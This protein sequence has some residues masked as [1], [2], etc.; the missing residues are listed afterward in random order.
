M[1]QTAVS[2]ERTTTARTAPPLTVADIDQ[3]I[4]GIEEFVMNGN[5]EVDAIWQPYVNQL[6]A[7]RA[8]LV[9]A[10]DMLQALREVEGECYYLPN[11]GDVARCGFCQQDEDELHEPE[12]AMNFVLAAIAKAEGRL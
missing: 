12:C 8:L 11:P 9:S 10:L 3:I 5:P 6:K 4:E 1:T 7:H 2:R